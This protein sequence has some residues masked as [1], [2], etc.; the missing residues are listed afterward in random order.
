MRDQDSR[1]LNKTTRLV[2]EQVNEDTGEVTRLETFGVWE[3]GLSIELTPVINASI[4]HY[5]VGGR[6][7]I[8]EEEPATV[9][10]VDVK[11]TG[12]LVKRED[13]EILYKLIETTDGRVAP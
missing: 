7:D 6:H 4:R 11:I 13:N 12:R 8:Y 2:V 3:H 1:K 10:G 5:P 9:V